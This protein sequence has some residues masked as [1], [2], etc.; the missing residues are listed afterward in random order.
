MSKTT[1]AENNSV[2]EP[3]LPD[4]FEKLKADIFK[5]INCVKIGIIQKFNVSQ[6]TAEVQLVFK[7]VLPDKTIKELPILVDCPVYTPQGGGGALR[8]P[9]A[10]GDQCIVLFSDRNLDNWFSSGGVGAPYDD[11]CHDL[12]DGICLVGVN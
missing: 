3:G 10:K 1:S 6:K 8:F 7:R 9:I 5:G 2:Q 12:S 11:R 4:A